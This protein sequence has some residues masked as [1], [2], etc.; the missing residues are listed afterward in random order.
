M[1]TITA[2][3]IPGQAVGE[4]RIHSV[5]F[6]GR[7]DSGELLA[8]TPTIDEV[9]T[10]DLTLTDNV[11]NVIALTINGQ[12]VAIGQAVQFKCTG[13]KKDV[14]YRIRIAI[15]TDSSPPQT[16]KCIARIE[17]IADN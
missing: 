8:G 4:V 5:D 10:T 14:I 6:R 9:T 3:E 1:P 17:G 13:V 2:P 16:L 12:T 15:T 11:V 7:L